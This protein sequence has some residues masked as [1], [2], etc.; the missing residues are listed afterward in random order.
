MTSKEKKELQKEIIDIIDNKSGRVLA[1]PRIGKTKLMIDII[2]KYKYKSI[3]WVTPSSKLAEYDI[4]DEF[5]KWKAKKY[6]KNTIISTWAS[7]NKITG[8]FDF[9]ILDEDTIKNTISL[10]KVVC[11]KMHL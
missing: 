5:I 7:L 2:K 3:L 4:P 8:H 9:I 11:L 6:L 1:A 10:K